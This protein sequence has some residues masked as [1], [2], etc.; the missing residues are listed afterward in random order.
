MVWRT[1]VTAAILILLGAA[2]YAEENVRGLRAWKNA[3]AEINAR[4]ESLNWDDYIPRPIPDDQNFFKAPMM[5]E[6]FVRITNSIPTNSLHA[7][8]DNPEN[9]TNT[10]SETSASNYL[11]WSADLEP[12]FTRIRDAVKR[13][14]ARIAGNYANPLEPPWPDVAAYRVVSL[15]LT[16]R[17]NCHLLLRQ[18][19][20][21]LADLTLLH[22]LNLT[23]VKNGS[24]TLV[25]MTLMPAAF[26]GRYADAVACGLDSHSWRE[27]QLAALQKQL[28]ETRLP[29]LLEYSFQCERAHTFHQLD[30]MPL[31]ELMG[32]GEDNFISDLGWWFMPRGWIEQNKAVI[33][34]LYEHG[35]AGYDRTN[36]TVS[37]VKFKAASTDLG[38]VREHLTPCNF[39]A[40]MVIP[41]FDK[42]FENLA[43]N[44]TWADQA[45]IACALERCRLANG[46]Y[47]ATLAALVPRFLE[48]I[49]ADVITGKPM[50]YS[51][52][53]EQTFLLYSVGW[54][55]VDDGG[56]TAHNS[57][58]TEDRDNGDWVWH[59]PGL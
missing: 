3:E 51:R 55:E 56:I 15:V 30:T 35:L 23:L 47:P 45:Q 11:A 25:M 39:L 10:I 41:A 58:G 28:A 49:P 42:A 9:S 59:Y 40:G 29:P 57:D 16:H 50:S 46:K 44:Q 52:K 31:G 2:F 21:A 34:V 5:T 19:D 14:A 53:D 6:W 18:P 36:E 13:P 32:T 7:L 48:K 12:V 37:P 24:P 22:D 43:R 54:N 33:A 4:G 17:A 26:A 8:M 1:L 27:P 38:Q 20:Q